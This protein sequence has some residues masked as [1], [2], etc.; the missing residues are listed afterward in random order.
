MQILSRVRAPEA[1]AID[2]S[3]ASV[4]IVHPGVLRAP[5]LKSAKKRARPREYH[6][7]AAQLTADSS[8]SSSSPPFVAEWPAAAGVLPLAAA[9]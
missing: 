6:N 5:S 8:S 3:L 9:G 4:I 7:H 2:A 1:V